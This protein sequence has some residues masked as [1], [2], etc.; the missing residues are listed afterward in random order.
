MFDE[1]TE[2]HSNED[3]EAIGLTPTPPELIQAASST[4]FNARAWSLRYIS[5]VAN[6]VH[7]IAPRTITDDF[8]KKYRIDA[9]SR[10]HMAPN[11]IASSAL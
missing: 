1:N 9:T 11:M 10:L 7:S 8:S 4:L 2:T 6:H 5:M 3:S